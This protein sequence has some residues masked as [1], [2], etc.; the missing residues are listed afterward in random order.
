[1]RGSSPA[2][3]FSVAGTLLA[4]LLLGACA[5]QGPPVAGV[6]GLQ[7][8]IQ[9][10][11]FDKATEAGGMCTAPAIRNVTATTVLEESET[12]LVMRVRYYWVDES[13]R[14]DWNQ[15]PLIPSVACEGFA[16][17]DFTMARLADGSL[18]V[19]SMT[20]PLRNVQQNFGT[21]QGS[22]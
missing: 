22:S 1:M 20:G 13:R 4:L 10:F 8:E 6:P 16:E 21:R 2:K 9:R 18:Q 5:M 14:P 3:T 11:Y 17:R 19:T 7:W 15:L 12:E